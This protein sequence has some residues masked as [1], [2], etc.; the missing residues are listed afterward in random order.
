MT[1]PNVL[2]ADN[3]DIFGRALELRRDVV[4][5]VEHRESYVAEHGLESL[6]CLPAGNWGEGASNDFARAY[7]YVREG[8]YEV[9]NRLRMWTQCFPGYKLLWL[10]HAPG[11]SSIEPIPANHDGSS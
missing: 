2:L 10:T 8:N 4:K 1:Y 9:L 3:R 6:F 7:R 11:H 5:A